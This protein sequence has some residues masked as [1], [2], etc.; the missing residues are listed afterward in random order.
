[1]TMGSYMHLYT[2]LLIAILLKQPF[3]RAALLS[4]SKRASWP[5]VN[6]FLRMLS[7]LHLLSTKNSDL[8]P[9]PSQVLSGRKM[10]EPQH[11][12]AI[13][14]TPGGPQKIGTSSGILSTEESLGSLARGLQKH[15]EVKSPMDKTL[16]E[17]LEA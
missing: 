10:M 17:N 11:R 14:L 16:P 5:R 4:L 1:M 9:L 6:V 13:W 2:N 3:A 7:T 15:A 12:L 8:H